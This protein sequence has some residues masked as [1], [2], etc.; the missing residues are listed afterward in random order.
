M[1]TKAASFF[2]TKKLPSIQ[3]EMEF[4]TL[5]LVYSASIYLVGSFIAWDF[6]IANWKIAGR[7][8]SALALTFL[9]WKA[10]DAEINRI[11]E[12]AKRY[13]V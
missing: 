11:F 2:Q 8:V 5:L 4:I 13:E 3:K 12:P 1:Q 7:V 9:M 6:N 10:Y